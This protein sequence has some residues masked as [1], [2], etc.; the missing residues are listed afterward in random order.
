MP[1]NVAEHIILAC[2][3]PNDPVLDPLAGATPRCCRECRGRVGLNIERRSDYVGTA[4][5]RPTDETRSSASPILG[6]KSPNDRCGGAGVVYD[7]RNTWPRKLTLAPG[8]ATSPATRLSIQHKNG[9]DMTVHLSARL[10]WHM[11]GWNGHVCAN[12]AATRSASVT[13]RTQAP[14]SSWSGSSTG[15]WT[16]RGKSCSTIDGIPPCIFSI[17]AFGKTRLTA[18]ADPPGWYPANDT[19]NWE[20]PPSTVCIW[21]FEQ[22][23]RDEVRLYGKGPTYDYESA[24]PLPRRISRRS[25]WTTASSSTT[26]TTAIRLAR[27][28]Q[29]ATS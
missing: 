29:N 21:P 19:V 17:N 8:I 23:Y 18:Y 5:Q 28:I 25:S 11:D 27:R 13:T 1:L 2:S 6:K 4:R 3:S 16:I 9:T 24:A 20:L 26:R 14:K 12:P 22:M 7:L 15:R 10:A